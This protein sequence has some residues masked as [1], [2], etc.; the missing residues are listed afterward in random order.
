MQRKESSVESKWERITEAMEPF[1]LEPSMEPSTQH[2]V[3]R[4][5]TKELDSVITDLEKQM[6]DLEVGKNYKL[7]SEILKID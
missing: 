3:R 1:Q 6:A 5:E 2:L 4:I 7:L